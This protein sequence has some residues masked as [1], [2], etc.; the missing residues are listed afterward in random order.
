MLVLFLKK[1]VPKLSNKIALCK[2][3]GRVICDGWIEIMIIQADTID[4]VTCN[5]VFL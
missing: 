1:G 4:D 2:R 5:L 3:W